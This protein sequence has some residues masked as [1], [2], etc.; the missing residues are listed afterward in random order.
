MNNCYEIKLINK[1][2]NSILDIDKCYILTMKILK[3][4]KIIMK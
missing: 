4:Y 1:N 3:D 2:N